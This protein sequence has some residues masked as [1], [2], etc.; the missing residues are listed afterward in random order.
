MDKCLRKKIKIR[1]EAF[2]DERRIK[3]EDVKGLKIGGK[4]IDAREKW[5]RH[6]DLS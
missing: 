5:S 1:E 3:V 6:K 2:E 4:S